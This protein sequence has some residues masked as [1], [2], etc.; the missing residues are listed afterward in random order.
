M[1]RGEKR[2]VYVVEGAM[3]KGLSGEYEIN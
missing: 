1:R 2:G 3:E